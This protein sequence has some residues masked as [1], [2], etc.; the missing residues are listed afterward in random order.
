MFYCCNFC[1]SIFSFSISNTGDRYNYISRIY[2]VLDGEEQRAASDYL[3]QPYILKKNPPSIFV[4]IL[5]Q[6]L[7]RGNFERKPG[8]RDIFR[9]CMHIGN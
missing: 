7:N 1:A 3:Q 9:S 2:L 6:L 5:V 8:Q 4:K